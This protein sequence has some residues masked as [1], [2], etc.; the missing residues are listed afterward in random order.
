MTF[1]YR[2]QLS[3]QYQQAPNFA[4]HYGFAVFRHPDQMQMDAK[5][6]VGAMSVIGHGC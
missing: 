2:T 3:T 5:D 4:G 6:R 1:A